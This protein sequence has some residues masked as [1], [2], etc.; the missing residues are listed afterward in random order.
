MA[1]M[2]TSLVYDS[3]PDEYIK[4]YCVKTP[5]Y[6]F[7]GNPGSH[8]KLSGRKATFPNDYRTKY[9]KIELLEKSTLDSA[10][11]YD[12]KVENVNK[13]GYPESTTG[14]SIFFIHVYK[15]NSYLII[16]PS[17]S[18]K[19]VSFALCP[20]VN[21]GYPY[22]FENTQ[23]YRNSEKFPLFDKVYNGYCDYYVIESESKRNTN[24]IIISQKKFIRRNPSVQIERKI[25]FN[26]E[27]RAIASDQSFK[28][29]FTEIQIWDSNQ[30]WIWKRMERRLPNGYLI[31]ECSEVDLPL[32]NK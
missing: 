28:E 30:D 1:E 14:S 21:F 7:L 19:H 23:P 29:E 15:I 9:V 16:V 12:F 20:W 26:D 32:V 3:M 4:Y 10:V 2:N 27:V 18:S 11:V 13:Y 6:G 5:N 8:P 24:E 17:N 25:L 31:L 22:F